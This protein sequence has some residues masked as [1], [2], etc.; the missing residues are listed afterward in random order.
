M[1]HLE[2][3]NEYGVLDDLINSLPTWRSWYS[4]LATDWK[5]QRSATDK[6]KNFS[7]FQNV[8]TDCGVHPA[9]YVISAG[10]YSSR[11]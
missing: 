9:S 8:E 7:L 6:F 2:P 1:F 11:G 10:G 5:I 3:L 4:D